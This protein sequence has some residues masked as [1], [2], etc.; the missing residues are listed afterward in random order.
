MYFA[1]FINKECSISL[2]ECIYLELGYRR[3]S[4]RCLATVSFSP[5]RET[6]SCQLAVYFYP[7]LSQLILLVLPK[8]P[9][10]WNVR[11]A[12]APP[13]IFFLQKH[14][15]DIRYDHF[16]GLAISPYIII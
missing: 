7:G 8:I 9:S 13:A 1:I 12:G 5:R 4:Q 10:K 6:G 16:H 11:N 2:I 14:V 15:S 3:Q